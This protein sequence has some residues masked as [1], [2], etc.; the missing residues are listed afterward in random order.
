MG[1]P[2]RLQPEPLCILAKGC[3]NG[4]MGRIARICAAAVTGLLGTAPLPAAVSSAT[5][6]VS[7]TVAPN[8]SIDVRAGLASPAVACSNAAP[9]TVETVAVPANSVEAA[10]L[11]GSGPSSAIVL[12]T[13]AY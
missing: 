1:Q 7:V 6:G 2:E 8:C 11:Q 10:S 12:V 4:A 13:I 3:L 9:Y 5:F